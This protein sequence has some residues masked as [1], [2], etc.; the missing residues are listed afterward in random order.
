MKYL[1][2]LLLLCLVALSCSRCKEEVQPCNDPTNPQCPNYVAPDPCANSREVSAEFVI[3]ERISAAPVVEWIPT[4]T[5]L[6]NK[7]VQFR[8]ILQDADEY[9]WYIGSE[10][11]YTPQVSRYFSEQWAGSNIPIT[12]VVRKNP[13]TNCFPNDDGY[14]S[15]TKFFH[16][17]QYLIEPEPGDDNRTIE[18]GGLQGTYRL[19]RADL[20]DSIDVTISF[21]FNDFGMQIIFE[22]LDGLGT[23]CQCDPLNEPPS[24]RVHKSSYRYAAFSIGTSVGINW[25]TSLNG[26]IYKPMNGEVELDILSRTWPFVQGPITEITYQYRGRKIN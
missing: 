8:A 1:D 23:V 3:E 15:L 26:S 22:N 5:T 17:S 7:N 12:L 2:S 18:H 25:C 6:K 13:D 11:L 10:L 19:K 16:V 20:P 14:D 21:C 4:D 9:K 24:P